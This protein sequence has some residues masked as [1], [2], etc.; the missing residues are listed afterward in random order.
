MTYGIRIASQWR[1]AGRCQQG[2]ERIRMTKDRIRA[3]ALRHVALA[4]LLCSLG[5][6]ALHWPW[7]HRPPPKPEPLHVLTVAPGAGSDTVASIAQSWDRNTLL[8]D[9][10]AAGPQGAAT[11]TPPAKGWPMRLE[12]RVQPGGLGKL[13]VRGAQEQTFVV[14][15]QGA[16]L[17][18]K[19]APSVYDASTERIT[20]LW[21]AA[22]DSA[23]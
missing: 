20:L 4:A 1:T 10:T 12:F 2:A 9:L 5:G 22:D 23:R 14:P 15:A 21:S 8:L 7:H 11:L 6:C 17:L 13:Q 18:L 19:L 3:R 16:P